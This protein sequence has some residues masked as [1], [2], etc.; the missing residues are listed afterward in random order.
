MQYQYLII[1]FRECVKKKPEKLEEINITIDNQPLE[2]EIHNIKEEKEVL[3]LKKKA[4]LL[5]KQKLI[6]DIQ[7]TYPSFLAE[8]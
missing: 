5:K 2:E 1:Y 4:L 3:N 8:M 6:L 7:T